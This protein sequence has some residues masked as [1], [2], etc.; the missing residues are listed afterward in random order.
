[1]KI[2]HRKRINFLFK[3]YQNKYN[4]LISLEL[5]YQ[6]NIAVNLKNQFGK[7]YIENTT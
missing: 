7:K 5:S 1:M 2:F 4:Y 6:K 3:I